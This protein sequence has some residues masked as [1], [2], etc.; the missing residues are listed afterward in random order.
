MSTIALIAEKTP[1]G[2]EFISF[3]RKM[4]NTSIAELRSKLANREP[5]YEIDE[6]EDNNANSLKAIIAFAKKQN[7]PLKILDDGRVISQEILFNGFDSHRETS[8]YFEEMDELEALD[9]E[10]EDS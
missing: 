8:A 3:L 1:N 5:F 7:I 4:T 9:D 10:F 6:Y 2:V